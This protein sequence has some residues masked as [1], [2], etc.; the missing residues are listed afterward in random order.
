MNLTTTDLKAKV[1]GWTLVVLLFVSLFTISGG[2]GPRPVTGQKITTSKLAGN[3]NAVHGT[4][5]FY[6]SFIQK[7]RIASFQRAL[8]SSSNSL[9]LLIKSRLIQIQFSLNL[10]RMLL[11]LPIGYLFVSTTLCYT[12]EK[13]PRPLLSSL[14][15]KR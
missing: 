14:Y 12:Q 1:S 15:I 4:Q 5:I 13:G 7:I 9:L 8:L 10:M 2:A 6:K 11:I 3:F